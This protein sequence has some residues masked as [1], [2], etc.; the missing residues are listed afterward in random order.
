MRVVNRHRPLAE[1]I[2]MIFLY[3]C[4]RR[5]EDGM[6]AR[7]VTSSSPRSL[8]KGSCAVWAKLSHFSP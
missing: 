3:S 2:S 8:S 4:Y 7:Y 6:H 1:L 5:R